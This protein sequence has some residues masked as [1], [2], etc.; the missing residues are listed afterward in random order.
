[1]MLLFLL[2][3]MMGGGGEGVVGFLFLEKETLE[4]W[5]LGY[6]KLESFHFQ[7]INNCCFYTLLSGE[8]K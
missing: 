2:M 7:L 5:G 3:G 8:R 1:M 4:K 6:D